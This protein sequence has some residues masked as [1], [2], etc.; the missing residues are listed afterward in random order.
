MN[1]V[2]AAGGTAGHVNPGVALAEALVGD[3]VTFLGTPR[4]PEARLVPAA[5]FAFEPLEVAGLDRSRPAR[6]PS[7]ALLAARAVRTARRILTRTHPDVV[8]G[9]GG[10][11]GLPVCFAARTLRIPVV[12]HEQNI[13][14][15]LANR[16][17]KRFATSVAVS[18]DETLASAGRRGVVVGNPVS[19]ALAD[20]DRAVQRPRSLRTFDLD[21]ARKTLLV[22]GGS[23]G[24][25]RLNEAAAGLTTAW[26]SRADRQILHIT[27]RGRL[28]DSSD[29]DKARAGLI[30]RGVEFVDR[31]VDAYAAADLGLC[32]GGATTVAELTVVG[33]PSIVVPYP[34]H[35]D[36][37]QERHGRLL[38]RAG[39]AVVIE[40]SAATAE[41]IAARADEL[42]SSEDELAEM[43]AAARSLA[44][45]DAA[46]RLANVVREAAA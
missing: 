7:T 15:G 20:F 24:A 4:G 2:I 21:P 18:F 8:V 37:Q 12:I 25:E 19:A 27:G 3:D 43:R 40:D 13:V 26:A 28:G 11:V 29:T 44:R 35:R 38:E 16:I 10:Y 33:L 42:L 9:M 45:P 32:R 46:S 6:A 23:Q 17:C 30:Y 14:L 1:V 22:F 36:R 34:Y 31:M 41:R 5:G 39:G